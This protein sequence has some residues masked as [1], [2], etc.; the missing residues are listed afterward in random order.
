MDR[1]VRNLV[2]GLSLSW[3]PAALIVL[4]LLA[5]PGFVLFLLN[6]LNLEAPVNRW[7]Q[8]HYRLSY[9][10]PVPWWAC[11]TLLLLPVL[12]VLLYFLKLKRK[13]LHVPSTF[14]WRKSIEDLRVNALFQW[15]RNNILLLLQLLTLLAL[16][17]AVM[18]FQLHGIATSGQ[19]YILMID[20]SASMRAT[21]VSPNRLAVA[22]QQALKEIDA[23]SD[24]DFGLV[25]MFSSEAT[26]LQ[27][28]TNDRN[29]LRRAVESIRETDRPTR[30]KDALE[31][32]DGLAN[33]RRSAEN[34]ASRPEGEVP[35]KERTYV[36]VEGIPTEVH[37]FSDGRF[38]DVPDFNLG[39][40]NLHFHSIGEP[41]ADK[42]DNL[43]I[44]SFNAAR[45]EKDPTKVQILANVHNYGPRPVQA[46]VQ[47]EV[48]EDGT[49]K[50]IREAVAVPL[51]VDKRVPPEAVKGTVT[52]VEK[53]AS[54]IVIEYRDRQETVDL[55]KVL[56]SWGKLVTIDQ[57]RK[58]DQVKVLEKDGQAAGVWV[59]LLPRRG[60]LATKENDP[61]AD[62]PGEGLVSFDLTDV[63]DRTNL[64]LH[65][66]LVDNQDK[67]ALDD[68]AWLVI[69]VVRK[70]K[71]LIVGTPDRILHA[72]FDSP[73][74]QKVARVDY[75][76]PADLKDREKY[77]Q[78]AQ[79]GVWDLV[80]FDRCSPATVNDMPL[81]NTLFIDALPPPW[82]VSDWPKLKNPHIKGW[83][84]QDPLL[85]Y[86]SALYEVGID[87]AFRFELDPAKNPGVP[88]RTPRLLESDK[89][90][91]VMFSL[92]RQAS[93]DVV[94]AFPLI[95]D[96]GDW[97][98]NWPLLPSFPL[99]LRNV[100]YTL[101]N[102]SDASGEEQVQ[103]GQVKILRPDV[104]V[105]Q[106]EVTDP[107]GSA[108]T[109]HRGSRPDFTYGKTET[110]GVY[111]VNWENGGHRYFSVNLLDTDESNIQPRPEVEVGGIKV[112][113]GEARVQARETWKWIAL[114]ALILLLLEW[115]VYN[116]RIFV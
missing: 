104:A 29:L 3:F 30:F 1:F 9:H 27:S 38:P 17:Y 105:T 35:G 110:V 8:D 90:A 85:R 33:P 102:V 112:A 12:V 4:L 79:A 66:S 10:I 55:S 50:D 20:N 95:T 62:R 76:E 69:G 109:L 103:P 2:K 111:Q 87:E 46:R 18:A 93:R 16:I 115:Y 13:P 5:I 57:L 37:L 71:V 53:G 64:V 65:A 58:G 47:L 77:G 84:T 83:A 43:G 7:L 61:A 81:A 106:I 88:P 75:L 59:E 32:A 63:D 23:R 25:L 44:V 49:L 52:R 40:L 60:E 31:L 86:L 24:N 113:A 80:V 39:N 98:T 94:M 34:E 56:T 68:A 48:R 116:R 42:V 72:F 96:K 15:L 107:Q 67:F 28:Y 73:A 101:G 14:L 26:I 82:K 92:T 36:A 91:A 54:S 108:A 11:L 97:N 99:F 21:D 100:V 114:A 70:A 41:G 74:T 51:G 45:D 78:R 22:K 89:D 6:L 19:H